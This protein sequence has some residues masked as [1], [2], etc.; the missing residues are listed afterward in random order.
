MDFSLPID[1]G[2]WFETEVTN[3]KRD[4]IRNIILHM[5]KEKLLR[6]TTSK[7]ITKETINSCKTVNH[8]PLPI[9]EPKFK[10]NGNITQKNHHE[11]SLA[12]DEA[13]SQSKKYKTESQNE[14]P[15]P[16]LS[17]QPTSKSMPL[18]KPTKDLEKS[19]KV[20]DHLNT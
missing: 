4:F 16:P 9:E 15:R 11:D 1:L 2:N 19:K 5:S 10:L 20:I 7:T 12:V 13:K 17:S 6:T 14:S 3:Q 8:V 18:K